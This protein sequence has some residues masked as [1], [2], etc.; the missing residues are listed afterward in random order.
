MQNL[1]TL[2]AQLARA[3]RVRYAIWLT[4]N[5][6]PLP[7]VNAFIRRVNASIVVAEDLAAAAANLRTAQHAAALAYEAYEAALAA[8]DALA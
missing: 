8:Y 5:Q 1:D 4:S 7:V 6:R 2:Y 3:H